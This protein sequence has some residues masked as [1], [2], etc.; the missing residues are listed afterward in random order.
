[1]PDHLDR[2][3]QYGN[4]Y[5]RCGTYCI[6]CRNKTTQF[7]FLVRCRNKTTDA[8]LPMPALIS[9]MPDYDPVRII[10]FN[11]QWLLTL[12]HEYCI[13]FN[14]IYVLQYLS[15]YLR[16]MN[17]K[18]I[19]EQYIAKWKYTN[20]SGC[21]VENSI[22]TY[23]LKSPLAAVQKGSVTVGANVVS[24]LR[25][26]ICRLFLPTVVFNTLKFC[27]SKIAYNLNSEG[28]QTVLK[29]RLIGGFY[30]FITAA[31]WWKGP[32]SQALLNSFCN[33]V[34]IRVWED[35]VNGPP[36]KKSTK[37]VFAEAMHECWAAKFASIV[38]S[39]TETHH[40]RWGR[41]SRI[42][43]YYLWYSYGRILDYG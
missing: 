33:S 7:G 4:E 43:V 42:P 9:W 13:I 29:V 3:V 20:G 17:P 23:E 28:Q 14:Y 36:V 34:L 1:M 15:R 6:Q 19:L 21:R 31:G 8:G 27:W 32:L 35:L 24:W 22:C 2:L 39:W 25:I 10:F 12:G 16:F 5:E 38:D 40:C 30:D 41:N 26:F 11:N 37:V 18:Q